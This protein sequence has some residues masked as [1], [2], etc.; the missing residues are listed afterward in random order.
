[1]L[2]I[3]DYAKRS[4][5]EWYELVKL[6]IHEET[7]IQPISILTHGE[8]RVFELDDDELIGDLPGQDPISLAYKECEM[9]LAFLARLI[10][11]KFP[12]VFKP[13]TKNREGLASDFYQLGD[14]PLRPPGLEK[15]EGMDRV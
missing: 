6:C 3:A 4:G 1:M 15:F 8:L 12:V 9:N 5:I 11:A 7:S 13:V 14:M 2:R 10:H